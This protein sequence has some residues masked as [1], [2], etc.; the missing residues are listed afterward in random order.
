[1]QTLSLIH[2]EPR[3]HSL[4]RNPLPPLPPLVAL[5]RL[6]TLLA[7]AFLAGCATSG[8]QKVE[9][10]NPQDPWEPFNRTM[11]QFNQDFDQ[12]VL[13]PAAQGYRN[14]APGPVRQGVGNF[15]DNLYDITVLVNDCLQL[16]GERATNT[17]GRLIFNTTFGLLGVID[18]ATPAGLPAHEE[19]FGQTLGYWG[20]E[21]GPYLVLPFFGPSSARDG[22]GLIGDV[23]TDPVRY[24]EDDWAKWSLIALRTVDRRATLLRAGRVVEEAALDPYSFVRDSYLQRRRYLIHDGAPPTPEFDELDRLDA[25]DAEFDKQNPPPDRAPAG[26]PDR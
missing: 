25:L 6:G 4:F 18:I 9:A 3:S 14:L 15:F 8:G 2:T 10:Q 23:Y 5:R 12:A 11:Y 19:D 16:K 26:A 21:S 17:A 24:V 1:M 13:K 7:V 20:V 22:I